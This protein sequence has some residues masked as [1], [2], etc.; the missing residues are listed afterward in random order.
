MCFQLLKYYLCFQLLKYYLCFQ[1]LKYYPCFQL[2][3]KKFK[4]I[5][6]CLFL[7]QKT[8]THH[9]VL[10]F[11]SGTLHVTFCHKLLFNFKQVTSSKLNS[12]LLKYSLVNFKQVTSLKFSTYLSKYL[13]F[14][15][16]KKS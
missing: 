8:C 4:K 2:L 7:M 10:L 6:G 5:Q 14:N 16:R 13:L 11:L 12:F 1:L 15:L 3:K 9:I